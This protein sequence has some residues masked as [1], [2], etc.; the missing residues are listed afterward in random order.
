MWGLCPEGLPGMIAGQ[1]FW[2]PNPIL[3]F[4][5]PAEEPCRR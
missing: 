2:H 3:L 1:T 4:H 5:L